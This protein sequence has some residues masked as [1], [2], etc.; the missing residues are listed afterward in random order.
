[1]TI[2]EA[3]LKAP[4]I[5]RVQ[6]NMAFDFEWKYLATSEGSYIEQEIWRSL[7]GFSVTAFKDGK[8]KQRTFSVAPK[9]PPGGP[10][11][12]N[13]IWLPKNNTAAFCLK[14]E[15]AGLIFSTGRPSPE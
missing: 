11:W 15:A 5:I 8:V 13:R 6:S 2:N 12:R 9:K 7:S 1:M 14:Q 10:C 3:A 4:G